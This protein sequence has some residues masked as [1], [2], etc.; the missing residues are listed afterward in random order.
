MRSFQGEKEQGNIHQDLIFRVRIENF[1]KRDFFTSKD[2]E[3]LLQYM[4][5]TNY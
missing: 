5:S 2:I 1:D 3:S 4:K